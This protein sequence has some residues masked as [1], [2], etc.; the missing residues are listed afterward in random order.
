MKQLIKLSFLLLALLMPTNAIA[1]DFEIDSIYYMFV[2]DGV[3]VTK[4]DQSYNSYHGD[5]VVPETVTYNGVTYTVTAVDNHAFYNSSEL[6]SVILP[7]TITFLGHGAFFDCTAITHIDLPLNLKKMGDGVFNGCSSLT[8]IVIP[9]LVDSIGNALCYDCKK[10]TSAHFGKSL[11]IIG[12]SLFRNCKLLASITVDSD[13][14][15]LDSRENCN[16]IIETRTGTLKAGC[17]NSF[18]PNGIRVIEELA[19]VTQ[20]LREVVIPNT[21]TDIKDY[22]FLFTELKDVDIPNSVTH[23]GEGAFYGCPL[24]HVNIGNSVADIDKQAFAECQYLTSIHIPASVASIGSMAFSWCDAMDTITVAIDNP[25]FDSRDNCNAIIETATNKLI[26]GCCKTVIPNTVTRIG[27][28]AFHFIPRLKSIVIPSS[29]TAIDRLGFFGCSNLTDVFS[30]IMD[31]N[32]QQMASDVFELNSG[33]YDF[34]TLHVPFGTEEAY[35]ANIKWQKFFGNIVG[36]DPQIPLSE[37]IELSRTKTKLYMG[38]TLRLFATIL[39]IGVADNSVTWT[40]SNKNVVTVDENG[41]L[42]PHAWGK[43]TIT[44]TTNDGR[45][46]SASCEVTVEGFSGNI[47][48]AI[49]IIDYLL[50][51]D[52]PYYNQDR[53]DVNGDGIIDL[54]DVTEIIDLLLQ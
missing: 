32:L 2:D 30:Y 48:M 8:S 26:T 50:G 10:L 44:A 21:V 54:K 27:E 28:L 47:N 41:I 39:P 42:T 18:I 38:K 40:S 22:A 36:F 16:A 29:I 15:N 43:A 14:P 19:F 34:R 46:L 33:R 7:N 11:A 23:I 35:Q 45:W 9:D 51:Q 24:A 12:T 37:S 1:Y 52:I 6:T 4:R 49:D 3:A 25:Y 5:V 13:N 17:K 53:Y 31:P 20:P